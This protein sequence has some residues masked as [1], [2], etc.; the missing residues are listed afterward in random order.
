MEKMND[1]IRNIVITVIFMS[2]LVVTMIVNIVKKDDIISISERRKLEQL[3]SFSI[4]RLFNGVFFSKFDKYTTD[5]FILR[6]TLRKLKVKTELNIF[7]KKDYNNLYE[8]NGYIIS[9]E[10]PLNEKSVTN[11][12][13]KINNIQKMY[14]TENNKV[15]FSIV[16]DKNYFVSEGNLKLDYDK[17][18]SMLKQNLTFAEYIKINDMLEL[19]DYYKTDTHWKQENILKI[20]D[21]IARKMNVSI[22][23]NYKTVKI[24][25]FTGAYGGQLPVSD[26]SDEIKV[27]TND[28]LKNCKVYN[29]ETKEYSSI[30]NLNKITSFDKYDIYLSGAAPILM[31]ENPNGD[32][33]RELVVFRDSYGSSLIP[34]LATGY[35]KITVV[36]TRYI[37]PRLLNE[38]IKFDK[39]DVLFIYSTLVINN[40]T[41]LKN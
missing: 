34:L 3:P 35:S 37:S 14:L 22:S 28:S 24:T 5:Q 25:N 16:P 33:T 27:F 20:A 29:Y 39:K 9:Q 19:S 6:D 36:D 32:A 8:Y 26:E 12:S 17:M 7:A 1:K 21:E 10:Y 2:I 4:S 23:D 13:N 40:S 18:E 30:Y 15:Y 38:Y 41:A 11:L 31:I